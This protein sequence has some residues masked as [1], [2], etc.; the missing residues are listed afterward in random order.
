MKP[1][2][3]ESEL[4][5]KVLTRPFDLRQWPRWV[6]SAG[7]DTL[8]IFLD[9]SGLENVYR[10]FPRLYLLFERGQ[11]IASLKLSLLISKIE[12]LV[13]LSLSNYFNFFLWVLPPLLF[14]LL[15][16]GVETSA[17][18]DLQKFLILFVLKA[19]FLLEERR[20]RGWRLIFYIKSIF[21]N[22]FSL[23]LAGESFDYRN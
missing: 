5:V 23:L 6:T 21:T 10:C 20:W 2:P 9:S 11:V 12:A 3:A 14:Y 18:S 4:Q 13:S 22:K 8:R 19:P 1:R 15:I 7:N 16:T 17:D